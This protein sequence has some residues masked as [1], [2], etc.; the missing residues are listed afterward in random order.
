MGM[1]RMVPILGGTICGP[2]MRGRVLA[3]GADFQLVVAGGTESHLDARYVVELDD[4]SRLFVMNR[5]LRVASAEIAEQLR[6]GKP[7]DPEQ[8]YFRCQPSIEAA[9]PEWQWLSACQII[10]TGQR[11]PDRV[12]LSLYRV[13]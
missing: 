13:L 9:S 6:Q 5:A 8:V 7:V 1:R 4:G 10:G 12:I 3:G 2:A 11:L